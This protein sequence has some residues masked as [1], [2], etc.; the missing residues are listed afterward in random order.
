MGWFSNIFREK[1]NSL[2]AV[3]FQEL[4]SWLDSQAQEIVVNNRLDENLANY[5][6]KLKDKRWLLDSKLEEW[7]KKIEL[8]KLPINPEE[9]RIIFA[10]TRRLS[11][12]FNFTAELK[13][14]ELLELYARI[15]PRL[16]KLIK[17]LES[18]DFAENYE[19]LLEKDE[20]PEPEAVIE[21]MDAEPVGEQKAVIN[22]LLK[23]LLEIDAVLENFWRELENSGYTKISVLKE[24]V[25]KIGSHLQFIESLKKE[26]DLAQERLSAT[27][28]KKKEKE[29]LLSEFKNDPAYAQ[30]A[31]FWRRKDQLKQQI[32]DN[33][34]EIFAIF[35]KL[36]P[37]LLKYGEANRDLSA[38][39]RLIEAYADD[40]VRAFL[41]DQNLSVKHF[42]SHMKALLK[43]GRFSF[44]PEE[45]NSFLEVLEQTASL[46]SLQKKHLEL[47][48][49]LQ[50]IEKPLHNSDLI[51][52]IE[53]TLYRLKHY[54]EQAEKFNQNILALNEDISKIAEAVSREKEQFEKM[55]KISLGREIC[56][57]F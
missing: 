47:N 27:G 51:Q 18:S 32:E 11:A 53:D 45:A 37:L 7:Q 9:V 8:I 36:K 21:A 57:E 50:L 56:L 25:E 4:D 29:A 17:Y 1:D 40:P 24:K 48:D 33:N 38:E 22:P 13:L 30:M 39:N 44:S 23:E 52:K 54:N 6:N 26:Q 55:V 20:L 35:S 19:F 42:F 49:E 5:L 12:L 43:M 41:Q 28:E 14:N 2:E 3:P 16:S 31:D 15:E 10:E 46:E 34:D